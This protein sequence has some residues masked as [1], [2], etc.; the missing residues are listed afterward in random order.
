MFNLF[1]C[2]FYKFGVKANTYSKN[3]QYIKNISWS[4][5]HD[6]KMCIHVATC[7]MYSCFLYSA[8]SGLQEALGLGGGGKGPLK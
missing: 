8:S 3:Q 5:V 6:Q 7:F 1:I 4:P 2:L